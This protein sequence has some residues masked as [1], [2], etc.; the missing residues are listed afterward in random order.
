MRV[1]SWKLHNDTLAFEK[2]T[3][4]IKKL[5]YCGACLFIKMFTVLV[6]EQWFHSIWWPLSRLLDKK[7]SPLA[8]LN[9]FST[10]SPFHFISSPFPPYLFYKMISYHV[11]TFNPESSND[12]EQPFIFQ[13]KYHLPFPILRV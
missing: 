12:D 6:S 3:S 2:R 4:S 1:V 10:S 9:L 11:Y 13:G 8:T 7:I 5:F